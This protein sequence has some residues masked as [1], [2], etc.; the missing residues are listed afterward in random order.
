[1]SEMVRV[2]GGEENEVREEDTQLDDLG[3]DGEEHHNDGDDRQDEHGV[4]EQDDKGTN[5]EDEFKANDEELEKL[6]EHLKSKDE[7]MARQLNTIVLE[8]RAI[9]VA[10]G[11][12][13]LEDVAPILS[14]PAHYAMA[15]QFAGA[16]FLHEIK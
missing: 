4:A 14:K 16:E 2:G 13:C 1:M 6:L 7:E 5:L 11:D 8:N 9:K 15:V 3:T 10:Y 12:R